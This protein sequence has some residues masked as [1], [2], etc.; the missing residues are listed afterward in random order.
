M[1]PQYVPA[2]FGLAG[3]VIGSALST[4]GNFFLNWQTHSRQLNQWTLE[5]KKAEWRELISILTRSA[6]SLADNSPL[7]GQYVPHVTTAEIE[8][9][10]SEADVQARAAI[11][12]R[13]FIAKRLET[14]NILERWGLLAAKDEAGAIWDAWT[15]LHDALLKAAH[16]DLEIS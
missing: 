8:R 6:R 15:E 7:A 11:Q 1:N 9:R 3:V 2:L 16:E 14:E 12:D 10:I 4:A 13:I 5:N